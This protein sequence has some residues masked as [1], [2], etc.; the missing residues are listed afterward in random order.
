MDIIKK[1]NGYI[2]Q[3]TDQPIQPAD[4][5]QAVAGR[6]PLFLKSSYQLIKI[7]LFG[8][9]LILALRKPAAEGLLPSQYAAHAK[10]F[11]A[12]IG[13]EVVFVLPE[14]DSTVRN[15]LLRQCVAF[16]VPGK[17][18]FLPAQGAIDLREYAGRAR[19]VNADKLPWSAQA[20]L[21]C[22]LTKRKIED[23]SLMDLAKQTGYSAMTLTNVADDL[24]NFELCKVKMAGK[25]KHLQFTVPARDLWKKALPHLRSPVRRAMW[26]RWRKRPEGCLAAGL[27]ALSRYT[28]LTDDN[29]PTAALDERLFKKLANELNRCDD[30]AEAHAR[31]ECWAYDPRITAEGETVD[32]LSL[33]LSL[34]TSHDERVQGALESLMEGFKW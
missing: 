25:N 31:L 15:R 17:Q 21:I 16:I 6:V 28:D 5:D 14:L 10:A 7:T 22:H 24:L 32:K 34:K 1:L 3:L 23:I 30:P 8:H 4:L 2:T 13:R 20:I 9:E 29:L 33:Y 12:A 11:R 27:T 26:V 19:S 18:M